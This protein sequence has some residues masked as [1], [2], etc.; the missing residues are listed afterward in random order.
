MPLFHSSQTS[1][2]LDFKEFFKHSFQSIFFKSNNNDNSEFNIDSF[3]NS[4]SEILAS[5]YM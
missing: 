3:I 4:I 1:I 5:I 2:T